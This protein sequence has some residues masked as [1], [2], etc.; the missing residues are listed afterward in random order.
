MV[1]TAAS[2]P[3]KQGTEIEKAQK[4]NGWH[5]FS[6]LRNEVDRLFE[7]FSV[8]DWRM[9]LIGRALPRMLRETDELRFV[10]AIDV[11]EH[12]KEFVL[13]AELP[14]LEAKDIEIKLQ[15]GSIVMKGQKEASSETKEAEY[16]ISERQFGA[17]CRTLSLPDGVDRDRIAAEFSKGILKV[18]LPKSA[19]A[20]KSEKTISVKAA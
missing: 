20:L 12:P 3:V 14:G 9:P 13:T 17:F 18:T 16:Y 11:A 19:E 15:N 1:E 2:I 10:P 4:G 7:D 8:F 6:Q 5:A